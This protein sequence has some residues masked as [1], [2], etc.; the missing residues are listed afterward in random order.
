MAVSVNCITGDSDIADAKRAAMTCVCY[1]KTVGLL[2]ENAFPEGCARS[3]M[4]A[5]KAE[6]IKREG[7]I[8]FPHE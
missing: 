5:E 1:A 3:D 8:F 4:I 7:W 6:Q 2:G